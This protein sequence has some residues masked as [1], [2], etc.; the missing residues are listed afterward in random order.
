[1]EKDRNFILKCSATGDP[2]PSV[3]WLKD[4]IPV[5]MSDKRIQVL[6]GGKGWYLLQFHSSRLI[7][8]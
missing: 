7:S 6:P 4:N 2:E 8:N 1:M 5:D 3:Y